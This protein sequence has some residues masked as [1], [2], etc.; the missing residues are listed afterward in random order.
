MGGLESEVGETTTDVLLEAANFEPQGILETS[1]RLGLRTEGSNRWEKGVDPHLAEPAAVLASQLIVEL[2]G[3]R[4]SGQVDVHGGLPEPPVTSLRPE[5]TDEL[6]GLEI[7]PAEQR[8]ILERLGFSVTD[9]WAVTVPT[10]RARD[11]TRE[12]DLIEE[13]ARIHGLDRVPFTL[14]KRRATAAVSARSS[15]CGA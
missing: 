10:W 7:E 5:R 14:P 15:V 12:V 1:E 6:I 2:T 11:V 9:D 13:V 4:F 8:D 3:A